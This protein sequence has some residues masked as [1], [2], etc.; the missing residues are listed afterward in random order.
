MSEPT[1]NG[2]PT[3]NPPVPFLKRVRIRNYKSIASCDVEFGAL[4]VLVGR[5]GSGK[6][7]FLDAL[8]F[9]ADALR[10]SPAHAIKTRGGVGEILRRDPNGPKHF[11]IE[12]E[13]ALD[14]ADHALYGFEIACEAKGGFSVEREN[15][16]YQRTKSSIA[17]FH[18]EDG[19][20]SHRFRAIIPIAQLLA[21]GSPSASER[22]PSENPK[23][24]MFPDRLYLASAAGFDPYCRAV[25]DALI[26]MCFYHLNPQAM[27]A[28]QKPDAGGLLERDGANI[29]SVLGRMA[30]EAPEVTERLLGFLSV[31]VPEVLGVE[32]LELG[33]METLRFLQ[34]SNG[35]ASPREF[36]A[37]S[38]SDGTL[39][40]LGTLVAVAQ[41]AERGNPVR[42]VGVEEPETALHPAAA[43]A[44]MDALKEAAVHT[45]VVVTTHS[46]DLLDEFDPETDRL[47]VVE[48]RDG[49]TVIGPIDRAS[50]EVIQEHL[51]SP[52]EL[53][54]IDQLQADAADLERQRQLKPVQ[55]VGEPG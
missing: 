46:P 54:R 26:M 39:C 31:I 23:P 5:N 1:T 3:R 2:R 12:L 35:S 17:S 40:A 8:S 19:S 48:T 36:Y 32:R 27:R 16:E 53:L 15:L 25:Y 49:A 42:L 18:C 4:T 11:A 51:Y 47:L 55:P 21:E 43:G 29:A 13:L 7:N 41:L 20:I 44:L 22:S 30:S 45:Q 50:R 52:G 14:D 24:S 6:S 37:S 28:I 10:I 38:M 33:P 34:G 9:V